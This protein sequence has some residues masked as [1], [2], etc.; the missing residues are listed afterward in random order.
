MRSQRDYHGGITTV[1]LPRWDYHGGITTVAIMCFNHVLQLNA[2]FVSVGLYN[3]VKCVFVIFVTWVFDK[4]GSC[5][6]MS[7]RQSLGA[8]SYS[9][10]NKYCL[11]NL[12]LNFSSTTKVMKAF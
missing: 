6:G 4:L 2:S 8:L 10:R 3:F 12:L 7:S 11:T 1:G 5:P 9:P